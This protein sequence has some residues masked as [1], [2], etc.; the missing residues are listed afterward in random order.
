[1]HKKTASAF[2]GHQAIMKYPGI[3]ASDKPFEPFCGSVGLQRIVRM[4]VKSLEFFKQK[5]LNAG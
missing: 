2:S 1:V 4:V 3:K 5:I